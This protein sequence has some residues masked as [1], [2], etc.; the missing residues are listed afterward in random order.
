MEWISV[1]DRMP[2]N[3]NEVVLVTDGTYTYTARYLY[4]SWHCVCECFDG[5]SIECVTH[6]MPLPKPP[7][8]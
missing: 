8:G 5:S 2:R 4:D 6:W 3:E 7:Q 1:K